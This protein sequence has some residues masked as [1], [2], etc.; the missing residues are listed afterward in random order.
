M[1]KALE[2]ILR[3]W[4]L[5]RALV[6]PRDGKLRRRV[7]GVEFQYFLKSRDRFVRILQ[8]LV[9]DS[10][11]VVGIRIARVALDRL[12]KAVECR[13]Q[14]IAGVLRQTQVVP[15]LRAGGVKIYGLLQGLLGLVQFL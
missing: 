11:K 10:F 3:L 1:L 15:G 7:V 6:R 4:N 14:L 9:A 13:F 2:V 8:I 5:A 12:L